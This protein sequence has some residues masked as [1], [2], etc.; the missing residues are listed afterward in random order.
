M[1]VVLYVLNKKKRKIT[2]AG[3]N[4]GKKTFGATL[5]IALAVG[6]VLAAVLV[7]VAIF[8]CRRNKAKQKQN[9]QGTPISPGSYS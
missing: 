4:A 2:T 3:W 5:P 1:C 7:V 6:T 9:P 8:L